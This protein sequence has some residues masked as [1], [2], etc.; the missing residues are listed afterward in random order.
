MVGEQARKEVNLWIE[1]HTKGRIRNLLPTGCFSD[2]DAAIVLASALYFKAKWCV[3]FDTSKTEIEDFHLLDGQT[4]KVPTMKMKGKSFHFASFKGF[5]VLRMSYRSA[6]YKYFSMY[7]LLPHKRDGL[8]QMLERLNSD[9]SLLVGNL[10]TREAPFTKI[11]IP[12][13]KFSYQLEARNVMEDLGLVLPFKPSGEFTKMVVSAPDSEKLC[14]SDIIHKSCI[15]VNE[16]GSKAAACS[17]ATTVVGCA[18]IPKPPPPRTFVADH[19][20]MFLIKGFKSDETVFA[21]VVI[22]PLL[23]D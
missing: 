2:S 11:W 12:K 15:E 14:I 7:F 9:P 17:L 22:N 5:Q 21:G 1:K 20:F 3:P 23:K 16:E 10:G 8:K 13:L 4:I 18:R 19:P 6:D